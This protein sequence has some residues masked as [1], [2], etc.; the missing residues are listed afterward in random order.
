MTKQKPDE[1]QQPTDV[2]LLTL[3]VS[4]DSGQTW[5]AE[6]VISSRDNLVPLLTS[7]WP[8]CSCWRCRE[9]GRR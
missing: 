3:R 7:Q 9:R 5:G 6:T 4:R 1:G 8:P 2:P